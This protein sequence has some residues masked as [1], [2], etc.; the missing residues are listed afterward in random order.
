[1]YITGHCFISD[2]C[3]LWPSQT[4][5]GDGI[6]FITFP[7]YARGHDVG[8]QQCFIARQ[9]SENQELAVSHLLADWWVHYGPG[10]E[11]TRKGWA[12]RKM[13]IFAKMYKEF[14]ATAERQGMRDPLLERD[15]I[16][17]FS[18]TMVEYSIDT[19]ISRKRPV[20][21]YFHTVQQGVSAIDTGQ[22][23]AH[24]GYIA[25]E[26]DMDGEVFR[27]DLQSF[28]ERVGRARN[29]GDWVL[30]AGLK[31]FGLTQSPQ[32]LNLLA[33]C[34]DRGLAQISDQDMESMLGEC[35]EFVRSR[36]LSNRI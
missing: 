6:G 24:L 26:F 35:V 8:Y 23:A 2:D 4:I 18:H 5:Y 34:I 20:E 14:F 28:Q 11:R 13:G 36:T 32:S 1:M 31:K 16:R 29:T 10:D 25:D 3:E 9:R 21:R 30:F 22:L 27:H 15:S 19:W 17:G 7:D 12:Y 33:S